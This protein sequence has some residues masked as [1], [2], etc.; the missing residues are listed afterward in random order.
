[1]AS[2]PSKRRCMLFGN[3]FVPESGAV[4]MEGYWFGNRWSDQQ[5]QPAGAPPRRWRRVSYVGLAEPS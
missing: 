2:S 3:S 1:M 5:V 4:G